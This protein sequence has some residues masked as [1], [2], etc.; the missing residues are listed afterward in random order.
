MFFVL[1][2]ISFKDRF[3][4]ALLLIT[5]LGCK[6]SAKVASFDI[7]SKYFKPFFLENRKTIYQYAYIQYFHSVFFL[8]LGH[9]GIAYE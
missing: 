9:F 3:N 1:Y 7:S 6:A 8:R 2:V 5:T 4:L